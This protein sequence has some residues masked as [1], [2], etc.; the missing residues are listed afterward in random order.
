[1]QL[2]ARDVAAGPGGV[3]C[4]KGADFNRPF[5]GLLESPA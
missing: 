3:G 2:A 5:E 1:M 4:T